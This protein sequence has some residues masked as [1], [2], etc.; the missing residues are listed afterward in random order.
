MCRFNSG[1]F[2]KMKEF[3]GLKYYWRVEPDIKF[4][5]DLNYDLF[6]FMRE[7]K[8]VYGFTMALHELHNTVYGLFEATKEF[9][10][11]KNPSY[12][13]RDNTI[14]FVTLDNENTFN[15]CHY[16]SNFEVGDLDFLRSK[17]Y[18][19]YFQFLDSKGGFFYERWGD[20]PIHTF[21]VSYM[22]NKDQIHYF[23]NTGYY[24][25]PHTQ[26]PRLQDVREDLHCVCSP[27]YDYNWGNR[28]S[29]LAYY[30][31]VRGEDR[32]THAPRRTYLT[33]KP[34]E[35]ERGK[36]DLI[37]DEDCEQDVADDQIDDNYDDDTDSFDEFV[38]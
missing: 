17:E 38:I 28:D 20:A 25:I 13:A 23:D 27:N 34:K 19:E 35:N 5:C 31:E 11:D 36:R 6:K 3:E 16:W 1:F 26:C 15:M 9:F 12:I 18:E 37:P 14:E 10:H 24:H 30:Y 29:C 22:L 8:K 2:Y 32:P 7:N 4:T 33:H 21:A